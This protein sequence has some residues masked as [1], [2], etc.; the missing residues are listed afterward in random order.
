LHFAGDFNAQNCIRIR[1]KIISSVIYRLTQ[2]SEYWFV[3]TPFTVKKIEKYIKEY[4]PD[5]IQLIQPLIRFIDNEGL[6]RTIGKLNVPCVYT[7]IDEN[8]YLGNCD[9]AYNCEQFKITCEGCN[10]KNKAINSQVDKCWCWSKRGCRRV[11]RNKRMGYECVKKIAFVA[12]KWVVERAQSSSLLRNK[13]FYIVD[14]YVNNID[15]YYPRKKE[16]ITLYE[17]YGIDREKVIIINIA[18]YT[19]PRKG[20]KYFLDLAKRLES[21]DKFQFVNVGYDGSIEKLPRNFVAVPFVS[22]QDKLAEFYSIADLAMIT[23]FSDTMPNTSLEALSCGTPICGFNVTGIPYVAEKPL[24][25]FVELGNVNELVLVVLAT[26]KK[27]KAI[28]NKCREYA[29]L[30]Y[31][32]EVSVNKMLD[33]YREMIAKS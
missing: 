22:D 13:K 28:S 31:S 24:G 33:I 11:A 29:L 23:S 14:E 20:V 18:K 30:R 9:N 16:D 10:G 25:V 8:A 7:M 6:F 3:S 19:N 26:L 1:P 21:N 5:V 17:K 2:I 15:V 32:P 27:T 12:P 4:K